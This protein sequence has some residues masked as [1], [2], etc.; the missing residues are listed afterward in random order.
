MWLIAAV[1]FSVSHRSSFKQEAFQCQVSVVVRL[2]LP[3]Y[4]AVP[5]PSHTC[6][7]F[8][9]PVFLALSLVCP[10]SIQHLV[11]G[12]VCPLF[13]PPSGSP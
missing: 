1:V 11:L 3:M 10:A 4:V 6:S 7:L 2:D 9:T 13:S 12:C 5:L 8:S